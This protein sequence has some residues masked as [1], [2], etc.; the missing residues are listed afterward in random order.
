MIVNIKRV[1]DKRVKY[2][3]GEYNLSIRLNK[4][5]ETVYIPVVKITEADYETTFVKNHIGKNCI[6]LREK[7]D[8]IRSRCEKIC[9]QMGEFNAQRFKKHFHDDQY[10]PTEEKTEYPK[11]LEL[12]KLFEYF[13]KNNTQLKT[14]T[15]KHLR[16]TQ[17]IMDDYDQGVTV[18]DITPQYLQKFESMKINGGTCNLQGLGSYLRDLRRI[19][20]YFTKEIK[21]IPA[22]YVYPFG[23]GGYQI[24]EMRDKK[25]VLFEHEIRSV[26]ELDEFDSEFQQY[27]RDIWMTL[28]YANGV[29]FVDLLRMKWQNVGEG[30][31]TIIRKKT[32]TTQKKLVQVIT[33]PLIEPLKELI[34]K[35]GDPTSPFVFGLMNK[36]V[37][38]DTTIT[39]RKNKLRD[40]INPE[41][42]MIGKK[43]NL[44]VPLTMKTARDCYASTL[45]RNGSNRDEIAEQLGHSDIVSS[46]YYVDSLG[47]DDSVRMNEKLVQRRE[48]SPVEIL[49]NSLPEYMT[50]NDK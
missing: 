47:I 6:T 8:E 46:G 9:A 3:G 38:K 13:I 43:L 49:P 7:V 30:R 15:I 26:M 5:K 2:A 34:N 10:V 27:A 45:K 41:L 33:I 28:Y 18:Y 22:H 11:T 1:L 48:K 19:I 16:T 35:I 37:Y 14:N 20:N 36:E 32:E 44:R 40:Q 21:I 4:K 39:N 42:R 50:N 24:K 25:M 17:K 12:K 23:K 31:I 29:N